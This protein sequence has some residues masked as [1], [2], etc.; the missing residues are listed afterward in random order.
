MDRWSQLSMSE[1]SDLMSLYIRNGI[2]SLEEIKKHYNS[3]AD[4]GHLYQDGGPDDDK[5]SFLRRKP[6]VA[7]ADNTRVALP[8]NSIEVAQAKA[9][10]EAQQRQAAM[11]RAAQNQPQLRADTRTN[12]DRKRE[13]QHR[14]KQAKLDATR[15]AQRDFMSLGRTNTESQQAATMALPYVTEAA[16]NYLR[17]ENIA[18]DLSYFVPGINNVLMAQDANQQINNGQYSRAVLSGLGALSPVVGLTPNFKSPARYTKPAN[19]VGDWT[20]L[21]YGKTESPRVTTKSQ[22]S[23]TP[24]LQL[25]PT[26]SVEITPTRVTS[27]VPQL[28]YNSTRGVPKASNITTPSQIDLPERFVNF[29]DKNGNI[30]TDRFTEFWQYVTNQ[31]GNSVVDKKRLEH[32]I[33]VAQTAQQL[34][35]PK[36]V[37][38]KDYVQAA[39]LHDIG[40]AAEG[41]TKAHGSAG[42]KLMRK[43]AGTQLTPEQ[44]EA[45]EKHMDNTSYGK[46]RD[47]LK[48]VE[49]ADAANSY[50][51]DPMNIIRERGKSLAEVLALNPNVMNYS[52]EPTFNY[53][54]RKAAE[55]LRDDLKTKVNPILKQTGLGTIK[56]DNSIEDIIEQLN[57]K[58]TQWRTLIRGARDPK[59]TSLNPMMEDR[60]VSNAEKLAKQYF[61]EE[62]FN[63]NPEYYRALIS[64][65]TIPLD[66]TG[67]GRAG[68]ARIVKKDDGLFYHTPAEASDFMDIDLDLYDALYLS[69]SSSVGTGYKTGTGTD[70]GR[71]GVSRRVYIPFEQYGGEALPS[72]WMLNNFDWDL[73]SAD[74]KQFVSGKKSYGLTRFSQFDMPY[75]L[76]TGRSFMTDYKDWFMNNRGIALQKQKSVSAPVE[77][78]M[79][80]RNANSTIER[81][82][83]VLDEYGIKHI[84]PYSEDGSVIYRG[85]QNDELWNDIRFIKD[86]IDGE[87]MV[88][89]QAQLEKMP[90]DELAESYG[91]LSDRSAASVRLNR[92]E[93]SLDAL[94]R[95]G[96]ISDAQYKKRRYLKFNKKQLIK[97]ALDIY[98]KPSQYKPTKEFLDQSKMMEFILQQ[99]IEPRVLN[100]NYLS[101]LAINT[102]G[103]PLPEG[104][105]LFFNP[106]RHSNQLSIIAPK[107]TKVVEDLGDASLD[108]LFNGITVG[109]RHDFGHRTSGVTTKFN[110]GGSLK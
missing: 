21:D 33:K 110:K 27:V 47:L 91:R 69:N 93:N 26:R 75:R 67:S 14:E 83:S 58:T 65:Q 77:D 39:L 80:Y 88:N 48:A 49:A 19:Q 15:A 81:I 9:E 16:S 51:S 18:R 2:S 106:N 10:Y 4:G 29:V 73:L 44:Y 46:G 87:S 54:G 82:N 8:P 84:S 40:V 23:S 5:Y 90:Y 11:I 20:I 64:T 103:E 107:G 31:Y 108:V 79:S 98:Y 1:K 34:P 41:H 28:T 71:E 61:G 43:I 95:R 45:I 60:N 94:Y 97:K 30:N 92:M 78:L 109:K 35:L 7:V 42:A 76:Q 57:A 74:P 12:S 102:G 55:N 70:A 105:P 25:S 22:L 24:T 17:N 3:F 38:R 99:G 63:S 50:S 96:I 101:T 6:E 72:E 66:P 86:I 56:L 13:T 59:G 104:S 36:G 89:L 85:K 37:S 52:Y 68:F 32:S 53:T 100:P 62:V